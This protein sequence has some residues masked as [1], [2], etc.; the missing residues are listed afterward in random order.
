MEDN[1][2]NPFSNLDEETQRK[3]QEIQVYEQGF[4]QLLM[5]KK[6]FRYELDETEYAVKELEKSE[7]EVFKIIAG[8]VVVRSEKNKLISELNHKKELI[9]LRLKNIEKQEE[10]YSTKIEKIREEVMKTLTPKKSK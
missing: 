2:N 9:E 1:D 7:G 3:I 5:Q 6:S 4:Q 8:Q 10:E